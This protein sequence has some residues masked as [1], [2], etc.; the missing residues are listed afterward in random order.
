[1]ADTN[2]PN[3][4]KKKTDRSLLIVLGLMLVG[5]S[6]LVGAGF[7]TGTIQSWIGEGGAVSDER[8]IK[9]VAPGQ[10]ITEN[11]EKPYGAAEPAQP[12]AV[13]ST[14]K[15]AADLA[16]AEAEAE[17]EAAAAAADAVAAQKEVDA[18]QQFTSIQSSYQSHIAQILELE[19]VYSGLLVV[20]EKDAVRTSGR[21]VLDARAK[22]ITIGV[23]LSRA[24][25]G[26]QVY[27]QHRALTEPWRYANLAASGDYSNF[28]RQHQ[29]DLKN[30]MSDANP[31]TVGAACQDRGDCR[32]GNTCDYSSR[33]CLSV[34]VGAPCYG[35]Q[36]LCSRDLACDAQGICR[37]W[38]DVQ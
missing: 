1:M 21:L 26:L 22:L 31:G 36:R 28:R 38:E 27:P 3:D 20:G 4:G 16:E 34:M 32:D 37:H 35:D 33:L 23:E 6:G 5:L 9:A 12:A 7:A 19:S 8:N 25:N 29:D 24:A 13:L 18:V 30:L 15:S 11:P 14:I 10:P 17:A 2:N